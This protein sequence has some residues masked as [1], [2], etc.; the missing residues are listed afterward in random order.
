MLLFDAVGL[1]RGELGEAQVEDRAGLDRAQ[2]EALHQLLAGRVAVAR[3]ADQFDDRVE[4]LERRQQAL[5]DVGAAFLFGQLVLGAADDHFALVGDVVVDHRAQV[6]RAWHVVDERDHVHAEGVLHRRVLVELVEHDLGDCVALELDHH[7]HAALVGVIL[8]VGD[9]GDAPVFDELGDLLDQP[10]VAALLD[11]EGEL[12]HDDRLFALLQR[13]DVG[14]CLDTDAPAAGLVRVADAGAPEDHAAGGEVGAFD[15]L[16]QP[17]DVEVGVL[18]VGD[19]G[20]D[21]LA[22]VVRGDVRGHPHGDARAA[23]DEQVREARG[24]DDRFLLFAVVV[25][26]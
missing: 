1:Q 13:L 25:R 17:V 2:L 21:H 7:A 8:D 23:V 18:D 22:E 3:G 20:A 6:E 10:A 26:A 4:V 15:V 9:L 12:G 16:H 14:A 5:E 24:K 19:R 11:H